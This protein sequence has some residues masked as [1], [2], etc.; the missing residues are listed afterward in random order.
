MALFGK[1]PPLKPKKTPAPRIEFQRLALQ[2]RAIPGIP[3][4]WYSRS[5][6]QEMIKKRLPLVKA[7]THISP[8]EC[9][10]VIRKIREELFKAKTGAEKIK[11]QRE[12]NWW[13]ARQ[14]E[15]SK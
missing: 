5:E 7:G 1:K 10:R 2:R 6:I 3:G 11:L 8:G 9:S 15:L 14:K 13:V 12:Y 4:K